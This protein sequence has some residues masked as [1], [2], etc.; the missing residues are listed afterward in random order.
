MLSFFTLFSLLLTFLAT[1][2]ADIFM[3]N[4]SL[5][6]NALDGLPVNAAG[7]GFFLGGSPAT[8]CPTVVG[9]ACPNVTAQTVIVAGFTAL[10]V[11]A[12]LLLPF[13][14]LTPTPG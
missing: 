11:S 13:A 7:E 14:V 9:A 6:G 12:F 4:A 2:S 1:A 5:P 8:Y 10:D 3:A